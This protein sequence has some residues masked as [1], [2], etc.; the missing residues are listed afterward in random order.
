MSVSVK[1]NHPHLTYVCQKKKKKKKLT[2]VCHNKSPT[3]YWFLS[4]QTTHTLLISV[5]ANYPHL[6]DFCHNKP[7]TPYWFLPQQ[8]TH[9]LL[10]PVTTNHPHLIDLCHNKS[11][12]PYWFLSQQTT[13]LIDFRHN[14]PPTWLISVTTNPVVTCVLG[15]GLL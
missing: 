14:K 6:I 13:H 2:D 15:S 12:T 7:P 5:K 1:T 11:P 3:P 9:T 8:T 10:I 4:Q